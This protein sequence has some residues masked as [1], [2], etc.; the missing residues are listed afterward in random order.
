LQL[1]VGSPQDRLALAVVAPY[2]VNIFVEGRRCDLLCGPQG[3]RTDRCIEVDYLSPVVE[4]HNEAVQDIESH[5]GYEEEINGY[6]LIRMIP[7]KALPRL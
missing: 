2:I 7:Q 5:S 1:Q 6:N 4:Q 3:S